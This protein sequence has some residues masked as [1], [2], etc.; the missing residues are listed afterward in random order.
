MRWK[1][2]DIRII[3]STDAKKEY[4]K[5]NTIIL[6]SV[7]QKTNFLRI[8]PEYGTH[9]SKDKIP[10][11]Y[12][13]KFAVNNIWKLNLVDGWR[14]IYSIEGNNS[15]ITILILNIFN[16]KKYNKKFKYN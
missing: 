3:L 7:K 5:L 6:N 13:I 11:E 8:D 2:K 14:L 15:E 9:I 16:H 4:N 10:K 1:D 12:I